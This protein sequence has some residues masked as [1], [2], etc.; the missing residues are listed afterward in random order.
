[1][2]GKVELFTVWVYKTA[3]GGA[4]PTKRGSR[5]EKRQTGIERV[6]K[7]ES[8]S[9]REGL[10]TAYPGQNDKTVGR[11]WRVRFFVN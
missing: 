1:M 11:L 2:S 7:R 10:H 9:E 8:T 3:D 6:T 4:V 5:E